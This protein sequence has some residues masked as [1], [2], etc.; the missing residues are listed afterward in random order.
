MNLLLWQQNK[1]C[2]RN[3]AGNEGENFAK[4]VQEGKGQPVDTNLNC[5]YE[6]DKLDAEDY[7]R[8]IETIKK[9][10]DNQDP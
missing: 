7:A 3:D 6:K 2:G 10:L 9:F 5:Q 8:Q 4:F 1:C